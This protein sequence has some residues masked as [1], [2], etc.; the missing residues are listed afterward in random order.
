[1]NELERMVAEGAT[2]LFSEQ[3]GREDLEQLELGHFP[4][5][6]WNSFVQSGFEMLLCVSD[7]GLA[8]ATAAAFQLVVSSGYHRVPLPVRETLVARALLSRAGLD[9]PDGLTVALRLE[10]CALS[11]QQDRL[12][13]KINAVPWARY[14]SSLVAV[15]GAPR[16]GTGVPD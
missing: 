16:S 13:G 7:G 5:R 10:D 11:G 1:M 15:I 9:Q 6:L 2:K 8:E 4:A 12:S 3:C 14:A